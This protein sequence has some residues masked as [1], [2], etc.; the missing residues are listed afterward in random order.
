MA[1]SANHEKQQAEANN[2]LQKAQQAL[3]KSRLP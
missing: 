2:R 1:L 3:I